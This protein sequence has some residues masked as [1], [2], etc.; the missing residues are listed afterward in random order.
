MT[1]L[2]FPP[3]AEIGLSAA[4]SCPGRSFISSFMDTCKKPPAEELTGREDKP[5]TLPNSGGAP[6]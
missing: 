3:T 1:A 6:K 2:M 5:C 4:T